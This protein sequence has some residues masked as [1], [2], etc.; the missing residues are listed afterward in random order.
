MATATTAQRADDRSA[1]RG[2]P[3]QVS[4]RTLGRFTRRLPARLLT[5]LL[6]VVVIYPLVWLFLGSVK[7]Q[8]DYL[9]RPT[10]SLP[11]HW[12]WGNYKAAWVTGDLG[13]YIRNSVTAVLPALALVIV[14][15][16]AAGFA[17]QVMRWRLSRPTMLLFLA[18]IMVPSQMILL[19]LF[20][21]YYQAG[22][23]GTLWPL[24]ITYTAT[25]LPLTV[26]MMATYF[27]AV[28]REVIE[29]AAIDGAGIFRI[30]FS[31]AF[32]M[33]RNAILTVALV[34]FFFMWNDLLIALTF[35]NSN[36]LRTVQVGLLNFT[37]E[38]GSIQYGPLFA[39]ICITVFST[40]ILFLALNQ[41]VMKGLTGGAVKG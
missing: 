16:S 41:K 38:F 18:G 11:T 8:A 20:T 1:A 40:L 26:F 15:G 21:I 33:V 29:A 14:L 9:N 24:I 35:T 12:M 36:S 5:A 31:V 13:I 17:L 4:R 6:L 25:G 27:R 19:P 2:A 34:Q 7:S 3:A 37:G 28:P 22:L 30:F 39:A 10:F 32:P 23:T